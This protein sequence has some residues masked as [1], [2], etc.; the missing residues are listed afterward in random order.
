MSDEKDPVAKGIPINHDVIYALR[1]AHQSQSQL[2]VMADQ[3][4]NILVGTIAIFLT[5]LFTRLG[6]NQVP[7]QAQDNLILIA[8]GIVISLELIAMILGIMVIKPRTRW[9]NHSLKIDQMPN[10]LFF[11]FFSVYSEK[12]YVEYMKNKLVDNDTARELLLIDL[13]QVG[14]VLKRKFTLLKFAYTFAT[15]GIIIGVASFAALL[16]PTLQP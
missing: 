14:Q 16:L 13:Y 8:L 5:F 12:E 6:T 7:D 1:T 11:G 4:A 10:P 2:N 9:M 15:A 3:K